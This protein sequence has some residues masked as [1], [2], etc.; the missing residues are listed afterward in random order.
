[1]KKNYFLLLL[2]C[3]SLCFAQINLVGIRFVEESNSFNMVKWNSSTP[4]LQEDYPLGITSYL[5]GSSIFNANASAYY[6]RS[7][8]QLNSF[9]TAN[10]QSAALHDETSFNSATEV[11]MSN[12]AVYT[13]FPQ[14]QI[15]ST[16][17]PDSPYFSVVK[18][19]TFDN[20]IIEI[21]TLT[22]PIT[23]IALSEGTCYNS[24]TADFYFV[25]Y[26]SNAQLCIY[27]MNTETTTF[28]YEKIILPPEDI[29]YSLSGLYFDMQANT[30]L[31]VKT[32]FDI[33]TELTTREIVQ[34]NPINGAFT[35]LY[36][37]GDLMSI[38]YG[39]TTFDQATRSYILLTIDQNLNKN[40]LIYNTISNVAVTTALPVNVAEIEA[41]NTNFS[42]QRYSNLGNENFAQIN[43]QV[44]PVPAR[45]N[46]TV[47]TGFNSNTI[48]SL[49]SIDGKVCYKNEFNSETIDIDLSAIASSIYTLKLENK[50]GVITKK[51]I[52]E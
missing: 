11:D 50:F 19:N 38:Q 39:S 14:N 21:G 44:Y 9:N 4:S 18:L 30:M 45:N 49:I 23:A 48:V 51:V 10:N 6:F 20:S 8:F 26:D 34:I 25:G 17:N 29:T 31:A 43:V 37:F 40:M 24:D 46:I 27:K 3:T 47:A 32:T 13:I 41:D 5:L 28:S 16:S 52:K 15:P 2:F 1:M 35:T 12:G 22:E 42:S 36:T 33:G 7:E